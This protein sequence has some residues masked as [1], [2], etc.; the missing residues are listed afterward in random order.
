MA[1]L[2]SG[3]DMLRLTIEAQ[4]TTPDSI[5]VPT[6][7]VDAEDD[8]AMGEWARNL[9]FD[10]LLN[11]LRQAGLPSELLDMLEAGID[12]MNEAAEDLMDSDASPFDS[13]FAA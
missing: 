6:Q 9:N 10:A 13:T 8:A 1:L 4:Q 11:N 3:N 5:R 12:S 2:A 7:G